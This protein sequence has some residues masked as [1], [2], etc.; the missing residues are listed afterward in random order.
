MAAIVM[1]TNAPKSAT[2]TDRLIGSRIAALRAAQGLS[3]TALGNALGVSFQQIQ[4]Y[5]KR[6]NRVGAGRL[7][8]IADVMNVPAESFFTNLPAPADAKV[9]TEILF[10]DPRVMELVL[11]F[12]SIS[13][14]KTRNNVLSIVK[15]LAT[16]S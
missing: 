16:A 9:R 4:K 1:S 11:A 2:E 10:N 5:E 12:T 7:Q 15:A 3:Q 8:A 13:R 6:R 14:D